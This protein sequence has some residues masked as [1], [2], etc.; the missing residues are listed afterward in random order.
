[1]IRNRL[2]ISM[3]ALLLMMLILGGC[4]LSTNDTGTKAGDDNAAGPDTST[5]TNSS[6]PLYFIAGNYLVGSWQDD[7]WQSMNP[8]DGESYGS[9]T[10]YYIQDLLAQKEYNIYNQEGKLAA[11][12][13]IG[14]CI[15]EGL[16]GFES[17]EVEGLLSPYSNGK[18]SSYDYYSIF[19]LPQV[20][21][22]E[23]Q[24]ITVPDY[25][26]SFSFD[27]P[28]AIL[29]TN[30]TADLLPQKVVRGE[31]LN[32]FGKGKLM[33]MLAENGLETAPN[34]TDSLSGDLDNDGKDE[35]IMIANTPRGEGGYPYVSEFELAHQSGSFAVAL[36]QDDDGSFQTLYSMFNPYKDVP[37]KAGELIDIDHC[38]K[39]EL[40]GAFDLNG[41]GIYEICLNQIMWEGGYTLVLAQDADGNYQ[42]VMRANFGM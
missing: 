9:D 38:Y 20:L 22:T 28:D 8:L 33:D 37:E 4:T 27:N 41:D 34:F 23:C 31:G 13:K 3:I 21:G 24:D 36:Y 32:D 7:S 26:F 6:I 15:G 29:A 14:F 35:Y 30:S 16:G 40:L 2:H 12:N 17:A 25:A 39:I 18:D 42:T 19:P 1:M 11:A 10:T 5:E